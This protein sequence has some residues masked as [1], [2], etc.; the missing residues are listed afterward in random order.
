VP[1]NVN[2]WYR[3]DKVTVFLFLLMMIVGWFN[4]Y[5]AVYNEEHKDI[6]DFSQR[7]GKQFIWVIA[8]IVLAV[9]VVIID[10]RFYLFFAWGVYAVLVILLILVLFFGK[11]VNGARSWFQIGPLTIQPS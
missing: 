11:E 3:I 2:I 9:L 10:T 5:A 7:Y 4:I 6:L 8:A 1:R